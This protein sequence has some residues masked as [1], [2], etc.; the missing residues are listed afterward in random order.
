MPAADAS[1]AKGAEQGR[2]GGVWK[3]EMP[4]CHT[5]AGAKPKAKSSKLCAELQKYAKVSQ[6]SSR[7]ASDRDEWGREREREREKWT[8]AGVG[9]L[10]EVAQRNYMLPSRSWAAVAAAAGVGSAVTVEV[11]VRVRIVVSGLATTRIAEHKPRQ[12]KLVLSWPNSDSD[13]KQDTNKLL[14]L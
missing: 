1:Q 4:T 12:M 9:R 5:L 8:S 10:I 14:C 2:G 11:R 13:N 7:K 6:A 3:E